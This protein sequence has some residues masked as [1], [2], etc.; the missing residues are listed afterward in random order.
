MHVPQKILMFIGALLLSACAATSPPSFLQLSGMK[1]SLNRPVRGIT[2]QAISRD[3]SRL[4]TVDNAQDLGNAVSAAS[5]SLHLWDLAQGR[6]LRTI[7]IHDLLH[8]AAVAISPDGRYAVIGGQ[9]SANQSSIGLWD[10]DSGKQIRNFPSLQKEVLCVAFSPDGKSLLATQDTHVFL[11]DTKSGEVIR[12]FNVVPQASILPLPKYLVAAFTPDGYYIVTGGADSI[13]RMWDI[14]SGLKVQ[15]FAGHEKGLKGGITG[16]AISSD[17]QFIF[18]SAAGDDSARTWDITTGKLLQK[19]SGHDGFLH[20]GGETTL[21]PDDKFGFI[22]SQHPALWDLTTGR[23]TTSFYL[24]RSTSTDSTQETPAAALFHPNGKSLFL[25]AGDGAIRLFD[26]TTG[27]EQAMLVSFDNDEWIIIT[28]EGYYNG[29][30]KGADYLIANI[31]G[32]SFPIERFYDTFYRPDIVMAALQGEDVRNIAPLTMSLAVNSPPP[33]AGF[34]TIP[35]NTDQD[36]IKVCYQV[37]STG[38]GIGEVRLF[39]NGKLIVS[40]GYYRDLVRSPS[41]KIQLMAMDGAAIHEQ[42]RS[43]AISELTKPMA[44]TSHEKGASFTDCKEIDTVA[45]DNEIAIT[46]FNKGNT[47][48]SPV[49]TIQFRSTKTP[50]TPHLYI[51]SIGAKKFKEK[52][53]NLKYAAKDATDIQQKLS[54]RATTLFPQGNIHLEL[55]VNE[56]A[57]KANILRK[58]NE[59]SSIIRPE[60]NFILFIASHGILLQNQSYMLTSDYNGMLNDADTISSNEF[61]DITKKIKSLNQLFIFD[62][63]QAGGIDTIVNNLYEARIFVLAKKMGVPLFASTTSVQN[64][65]DGFQGNGIFT[66]CL[67]EG[68]DNKQE[69]DVNNDKIISISEFGTF[70]QQATIMQSKKLGYQQTPLIINHGKDKP[71]YKTQ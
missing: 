37:S 29:S 69:A 36:K 19:I 1:M 68:L 52:A 27:R 44:I 59:L 18:T 66:H 21:S 9:P 51:L 41:E 33:T 45:G 43:V 38:G 16:I 63:C 10:L 17:S 60:D 7:S 55:L 20:G 28:A 13:L 23:K 30:I 34:A 46:A 4:I 42:M 24:D 2:A 11:F 64:A 57:N 12:Q 15:H 5:G 3:G 26:T 31:G 22:A 40:D 47:L 67:L 56:N 32:K 6:Q 8:I 48:Q 61:V 39:H 50:P 58:I 49:Q 62:S 25:H 65:L 35:S 54:N 14:K 71:L 53:V 70:A